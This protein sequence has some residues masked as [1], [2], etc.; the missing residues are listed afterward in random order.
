MGPVHL[1][2]ALLLHD[3][4]WP[5]KTQVCKTF[6][7]PRKESQFNSKRWV[8]KQEESVSILVKFLRNIRS[9]KF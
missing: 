8:K 9:E 2:K 3:D 1:W 7:K 5:Q 6:L 4:I